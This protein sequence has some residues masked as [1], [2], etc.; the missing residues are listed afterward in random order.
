MRRLHPAGPT[1]PLVLA[2]VVLAVLSSSCSS[3]RN[4]ADGTTTA[5]P[6]PSSPAK[7]KILE[8]RNGEVIRGSNLTIKVRLTGALIVPA[9]T[10][11]IVPTQGHLHVFLDDRIVAMN[12]STIGQVPNVTP[13][14]HVLRVEF[15]ASD[16]LPFDPR[17]FTAVTFQDK[18]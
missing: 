5:S 3:G 11:H 4:A 13:G 17:V 12:F 15:V 6:R 1:V 9:T 8:P 14:V 2:V 10:T 18:P 16:H 7:V